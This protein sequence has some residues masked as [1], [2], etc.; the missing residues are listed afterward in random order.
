MIRHS[1]EKLDRMLNE[2]LNVVRI[3]REKIYPEQI[4]FKT[5]LD[6]VLNAFESTSGFGSI[7]KKISV[8]T[9]KELRTDKNYCHLYSTI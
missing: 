3:K 9:H 6:F 2:L 4:N 8:D 5:E 1:A 7:C